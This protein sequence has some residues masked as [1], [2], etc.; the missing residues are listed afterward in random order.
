MIPIFQIATKLA[1]IAVTFS[2][3]GFPELRVWHA[4]IGLHQ[5][6]SLDHAVN[7]SGRD[8]VDSIPARSPAMLYQKGKP[9]ARVQGA[10]VD[11]ETSTVRFA[12]VDKSL[13]LDV[14]KEFEFQ[15]WRL[16]YRDSQA[17]SSV[18]ILGEEDRA[19]TNMTCDIVGVRG[20]F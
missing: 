15:E 13:A 16:K 6:L 5:L 11:L 17:I 9:V 10:K 19:F 1:I 20:E 12:F 4:E 2:V 7:R 14:T 3:A 8:A 18:R